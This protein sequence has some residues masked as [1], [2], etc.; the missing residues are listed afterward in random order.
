MKVVLKETCGRCQRVTSHEVSWNEAAEIHTEKT[1][2]AAARITVVEDIKA[3]LE[4]TPNG[5]GIAMLFG[6]KQPDGTYEVTALNDLCT[7]TADAQRLTGCVSRVNGL[8]SEI[9]MTAPK[10]LKVRKPKGEAVAVTADP[11]ADHYD[12]EAPEGNNESV[13]DVVASPKKKARK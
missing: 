8:L 11:H 7:G 3:A 13:A 4:A 1:E 2:E 9:F 12:P 10:A 6:I 5:A